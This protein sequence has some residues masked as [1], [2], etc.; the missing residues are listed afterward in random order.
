MDNFPAYTLKEVN[1]DEIFALE[2]QK[3]SL[4]QYMSIS[5]GGDLFWRFVFAAIG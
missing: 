5:G 2:F 3:W 1:N 4:C